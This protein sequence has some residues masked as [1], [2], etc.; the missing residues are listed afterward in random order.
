MKP[1]ILILHMGGTI[2]MEAISDGLRPITQFDTL[3]QQGLEKIASL[4]SRIDFD[5]IAFDQ[6][7]DSADLTPAS[8]HRLQ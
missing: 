1:R 2:G 6:P 3:L 5:I 4:S 7:M 8:S